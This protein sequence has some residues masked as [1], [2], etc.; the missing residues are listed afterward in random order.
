MFYSF[1]SDSTNVGFISIFRLKQIH[2]IDPRRHET[3]L[4]KCLS[5]RNV[6]NESSFLW[7]SSVFTS[8][9]MCCVVLCCVV[10]CCAHMLPMQFIAV[11]SSSPHRLPS[12]YV[13]TY[14][15]ICTYVCIII[16]LFPYRLL[17]WPHSSPSFL[18]FSPLILCMYTKLLKLLPYN[19]ARKKQVFP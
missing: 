14:L 9:H 19:T 17:S 13:G 2:W 10:L 12:T 11:S 3:S 6:H 1:L 18:T 16:C 15:C 4:P 5:N 7:K 8:L